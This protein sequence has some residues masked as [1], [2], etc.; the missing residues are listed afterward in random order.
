MLSR[1]AAS[2]YS[3]ARLV[4]RADHLARLLDVHSSVYL[5]RPGAMSADYWPRFLGACGISVEGSGHERAVEL[6]LGAIAESV[7][8]A[9]RRALAVRP[10]ISTEVFEQLNVLHWQVQ[11]RGDAEL[12]DF[13]VGVEYGVHLLSGLADDSMAHDDAWSFMRLGKHLERA[14]NVVRLVSR[15]LGEMDRADPVLWAAVLRCCWAFEAYRLRISAPVTAERVAAF[16]L[17]DRELP[18]SAGYCVSESLACVRRIDGAG[19]QSGPHRVLGR[20]GALFEYADPAELPLPE[21]ERLSAQLEDELVRT[22]F[23]PT[24][25]AAPRPLVVEQLGSQ[26]Q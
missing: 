15:K 13:L 19:R 17:L 8:E 26:Q 11:E 9:R 20:L 16:L 10:S 7:G 23:Q 2:L 18:R 24:S 14:Q 6:A 4:E 3:A 5:D 1:V 12:H 25:V 21:F 22:Y